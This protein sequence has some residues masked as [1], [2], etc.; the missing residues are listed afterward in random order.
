MTSDIVDAGILY[1]SKSVNPA[2]GQNAGH[3]FSMVTGGMTPSL[4]GL[5]GSE[6]LGGG[7]KA[8]KRRAWA[9]SPDQHRQRRHTDRYLRDGQRQ[10]GAHEDADDAA[11]SVAMSVR[12]IA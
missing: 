10:G 8:G 3:Q 2:T 1:T 5:K 11:R 6:D 12:R 4:F 7:V 9:A